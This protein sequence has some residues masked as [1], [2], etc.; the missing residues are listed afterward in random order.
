MAIQTPD[1]ITVARSSLD[2]EEQI[3]S[4]GQTSANTQDRPH[5]DNPD[6]VEGTVKEEPKNPVASEENVNIS[7]ATFRYVVQI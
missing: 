6:T 3:L 7:T 2:Q 5:E 1:M 4:R